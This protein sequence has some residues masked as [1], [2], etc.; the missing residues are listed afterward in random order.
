VVLIVHG[1]AGTISPSNY[2]SKLDVLKAAV[3]QGY[4]V[5]RRSDSSVDAVEAAVRVMEDREECNAGQ[6][7]YIA[8]T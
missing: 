7:L 2:D 1:G 6:R 3:V 8:V 4:E 5:L